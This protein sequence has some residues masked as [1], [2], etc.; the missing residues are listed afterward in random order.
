RTGSD[1]SKPSSITRAAIRASVSGP[2]RKSSI[3]ITARAGNRSAEIKREIHRDQRAARQAGGAD[4]AA[5]RQPARGE[6]AGISRLHAL[7]KA[8]QIDQSDPHRHDLIAAE[9]F[10]FD[11]RVE[12]GEDLARLRLDLL[13]QRRAI[14]G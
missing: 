1:I 7:L 5:C 13:G 10:G 2:A 9:A 3:G 11:D 8:W 6:E 4:D 12:I 14:I